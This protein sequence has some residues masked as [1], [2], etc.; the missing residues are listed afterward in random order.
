[1]IDSS[2]AP[3]TLA[4]GKSTAE[5]CL[6]INENNIDIPIS[7]PCYDKDNWSNLKSVDENIFKGFQDILSGDKTSNAAK[8]WIQLEN[9]NKGEAKKIRNQYIIATHGSRSAYILDKHSEGRAKILYMRNLTTGTGGAKSGSSKLKNR[10]PYK[11]GCGLTDWSSSE[12]KSFE[13]NLL[14]PYQ[15]RISKTLSKYSSINIVNLSL[16]YKLS[17]IKE[18]NP[19]CSDEQVLKEYEV[20]TYSWRNLIRNHPN[21]L[22]IVAAGNENENF[23][24]PKLMTNDLWPKMFSFN[25]K[26]LLLVGSMNRN[27]T[28]YK[29]SNFGRFVEVMALG[30]NLELNSPLPHN[31]VGHPT[32]VRGTSF[33]TPLVS[34]KAITIRKNGSAIPL[35][36]EDIIQ[37]FLKDQK[38]ILLKTYL[39]T[40]K[41]INTLECL[42]SILSLISGPYLWSNTDKLFLKGKQTWDFAPFLIQVV[43]DLNSQA[44]VK[45]VEHNNSFIPALLL[46]KSD[47]P[48]DLLITLHHEIYHY[49]TFSNAAKYFNENQ[50][51]HNCAT[52]YQIELAKDEVLAFQKEI[53]F[54]NQSP[55][56]FKKE[57][58]QKKFDSKLL[59]L[60]NTTYSQ[61]Y[62]ILKDK[63]DQDKNFIIKK[64]IEFGEYPQCLLK[65]I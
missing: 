45:L 57:A 4:S 25:L 64:Y 56:W 33:S 38:S 28:K 36:K 60:K 44:K 24:D 5:T 26:N 53:D 3:I 42:S 21:T 2:F 58:N 8:K 23:D 22:F 34:A 27:G 59:S 29:T 18:D 12:V 31:L 48:Y 39:N 7:G 65:I 10:K 51:I 37:L 9:S 62:K 46:G 15:E 61:Y 54:Y 13:G 50:K 35:L 6:L 52:R 14:Q 43:E 32:T 16:G 30:E 49:S 41:S 17:W 11:N 40:C 20:L 47:S 19:K 63:I 1:L 55:D